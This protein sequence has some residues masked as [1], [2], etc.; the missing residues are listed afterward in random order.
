M[1]DLPSSSDKAAN[2]LFLKKIKERKKKV[3][4][5]GTEPAPASLWVWPCVH[6]PQLR[7]TKKCPNK[8]KQMIYLVS[9]PFLEEGQSVLR[10][11]EEDENPTPYSTLFFPPYPQTVWP[12]I[13]CKSPLAPHG[14]WCFVWKKDLC[15]NNKIMKVATLLSNPYLNTLLHQ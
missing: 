12:C 4:W 2:C 8:I 6:K 15:Y 13:N 5:P 7:E 3:K 11:L 10:S 9:F 1:Y 14:W